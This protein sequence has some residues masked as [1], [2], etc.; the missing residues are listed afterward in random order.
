MCL[1]L[2]QRSRLN[3][4]IKQN[5]FN[6]KFNQF[7]IVHSEYNRNDIW[8]LLLLCTIYNG[9]TISTKYNFTYNMLQYSIDCLDQLPNLTV[10]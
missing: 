6:C 5:Q 9:F 3:K 10:R 8:V 1:V 4:Y 2:H 7:H